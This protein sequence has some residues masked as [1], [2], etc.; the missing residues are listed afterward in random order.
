MDY[1]VEA[2]GQQN[3]SNEWCLFIGPSK[4]SLKVV[5]SHNGSIYH[6]APTVGAIHTKIKWQYA[7][8][9]IYIRYGKYSWHIYGDLKVIVLQQGLRLENSCFF[10]EWERSARASHYSR[11]IDQFEKQ[12][13]Q[14][15]KC[16][17]VSLKL[18]LQIFSEKSR[19]KITSHLLKNFSIPTNSSDT[20]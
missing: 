8:S 15:K 10:C 18:E 1:S 5:L 20:E 13:F 7:P 19:E 9:F 3:D 16:S 17:P 2:L 11:N 12:W 4:L 6:S 14:G